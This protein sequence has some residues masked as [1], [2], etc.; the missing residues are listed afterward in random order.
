M[1]LHFDSESISVPKGCFFLFVIRIPVPVLFFHVVSICAGSTQMAWG[2]VL[3]RVRPVASS[4]VRL[5]QQQLTAPCP[6]RPFQ[7]A[8]CS[9]GRRH[10]FSS[11][12]A[13]SESDDASAAEFCVSEFWAR[14]DQ[15]KAY[16]WEQVCV[17]LRPLYFLVISWLMRLVYP[18]TIRS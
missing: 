5:H 14:T 8:S 15:L 6:S 4:R 17:T 16:L 7:R 3:I 12:A 13:Y 18:L 10:A 1:E 9:Y 11:S 2:Q